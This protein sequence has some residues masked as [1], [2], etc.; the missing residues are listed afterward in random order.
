[1]AIK[2]QKYDSPFPLGEEIVKL[3][4]V[5]ES[6]IMNALLQHVHPTRRVFAKRQI[7]HLIKK[8]VLFPEKR[9]VYIT[10]IKELIEFEKKQDGMKNE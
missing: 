7:T 4:D 9:M 3:E 6:S 10:L 2:S 5:S 8:M 1:M